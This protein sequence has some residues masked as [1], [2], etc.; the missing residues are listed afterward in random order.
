MEIPRMKKPRM[1]PALRIAVPLIAAV[2]A[3]AVGASTALAAVWTSSD[4]YGSW[5]NGGYTLYNNVW[6]SNPGP[7]TI[8]ANSY[9]DWGVYSDQPDTSGVKSYPEVTKTINE[10]VSS[11]TSITSSFS[12]SLPSSGD[13]ESAYDI[14]ADN[15]ADEIMLWTYTQNVGPLGTLQTTASVGG[16]TWKI[17]KGSNGSNA[18][19]SFVR[20]SNETSGSVDIKAVF[21]WLSSEG[22]LTNATLN[23]VDFGWEITSTNSTTEDFTVTSYSLST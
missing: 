14:W 20:T 11:L 9:H 21:T 22:W 12:D 16:S 17:Y 13:F 18:V 7:Q 2:T 19:F 4:L 8:W 5:S 1:L 3:I 15:N 23:S 10:A 6:G